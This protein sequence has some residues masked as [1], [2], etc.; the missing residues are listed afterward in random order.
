MNKTSYAL[1]MSIAHNLMQ[2][3]VKDLEFNDFFEGLKATLTGE[4]PALSIEEAGNELEKF[5]RELEETQAAAAKAAG[6]EWL[7][8]NGKKDGVTTLASGLQYKVLT[9]GKGKKPGLA[10]KVKCHYEGRFVDGQVFDSSY[11]RNEPAVFGVTQVIRGWTEAL[12]MM[13][14]GSKWELYIPY[15]LAYGEQGVQGS[16]PPYATLVFTVELIEV[17]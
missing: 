4:T 6:E 1:G 14:E 15:N 9:K 13:S 16:I 11:A 10:D 3:G 8:K 12:P 5:F 7:T 17:L 2:S